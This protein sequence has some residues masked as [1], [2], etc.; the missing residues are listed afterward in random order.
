MRDDCAILLVED[1]P[2]DEKLTLRALEKSRVGNRVDVV[3][4]GVEALDYLFAQGAHLDR[5]D[6]RLPSVVLLDLQLPKLDGLEVLRQIR[7]NPNTALLPVVILTSSDEDQDRL[8]GYTLGVNSYVCKPVD[9]VKFSDAVA[10][11][12]LYWLVINQLPPT[13]SRVSE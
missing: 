7:A 1:N 8:R 9:F 5:V 11:L 12:G 6:K 13:M 10:Q 2:K 4:D 3:R